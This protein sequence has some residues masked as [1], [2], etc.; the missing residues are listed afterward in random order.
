[1]SSRR[2]RGESS[3]DILGQISQ[4]EVA[5]ETPSLT[6]FAN[7]GYAS[8][9]AEDVFPELSR[10]RIKVQLIE[11]DNI[12]P[13]LAQP[14]RVMP[15]SV[16]QY[17]SGQ[18]NTEAFTHLF[19]MW[20]KEVNLER[21]NNQFDLFSYLVS[22][23]TERAPE[24]IDETASAPSTSIG[25]LETA[26]LRIVSLAASI[27]RDG[28]T[29]PITVVPKGS[30]Y[31][32]ETG[33]RRWLAFQMLRIHF[34]NETNW[35]RIPARVMERASIWRQA[36]ENNVRSDLNAIA[37]ARQLAL[38]IMDL[39]MEQGVK[40][41]PFEI[42]KNEQ[43]FYAQVADP[44][45]FKIP[46]GKGELVLNAMGFENKST[47]KRYR[48]LLTLPSEVWTR[49]D[50]YNVPESV[51][52]QLIN[53]PND[54]MLGFINMWLET[55]RLSIEEKGAVWHKDGPQYGKFS[56]LLEYDM[57]QWL[58]EY[59]NLDENSRQLVI[60]FLKELLAKLGHA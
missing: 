58:G 40:F 42:F 45:K 36:S 15:S 13:D 28:L 41:R 16:R 24:R 34:P 25:P 55:G 47:I 51:L 30:S 12:F 44:V 46:Y 6:D 10:N 37:K 48:D 7:A 49:A 17:W 57:D 38:I 50:D 60:G 22:D 20:V 14:R 26:L 35:K 43:A 4:N 9:V 1:M 5:S 39:Y 59:E 33:E 3:E 29:N 32:I 52:R 8:K 19:D 53:K 31:I 56:R 54:Q 2:R 27:R 21:G 23:V 11:L 18:G